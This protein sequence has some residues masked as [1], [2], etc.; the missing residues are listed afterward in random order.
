MKAN[1]ASKPSL[2]TSNTLMPINKHVLANARSAGRMFTVTAAK[3]NI[4]H[5]GKNDRG[6][7]FNLSRRRC[8]DAAKTALRTA[9]PPNLTLFRRQLSKGCSTCA[10]YPLSQVLAALK[11]V[12]A[13]QLDMLR[14]QHKSAVGTACYS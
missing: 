5:R 6:L 1:P 13:S 7:I 3:T 10:Q 14:K 11:I 8:I 4:P 12:Y 2:C 9:K